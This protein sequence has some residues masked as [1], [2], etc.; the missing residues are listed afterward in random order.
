MPVGL[1]GG[2]QR[3]HVAG[4][5][6]RVVPVAPGLRLLALAGGVPSGSDSGVKGLLG[7]VSYGGATRF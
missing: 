6:A 5:G 4:C 7:V 1:H 3:V 2:A